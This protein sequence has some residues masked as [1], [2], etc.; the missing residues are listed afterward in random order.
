MSVKC[1]NY[2]KF[3]PLLIKLRQSLDDAA[4]LQYIQEHFENA[5]Q[6]YGVF[7]SRNPKPPTGNSSSKDNGTAADLGHGRGIE[8]SSQDSVQNLFIGNASAYTNLKR[9]FSR[10]IVS[11][12]I[13]DID[14]ESFV[15]ANAVDEETGLTILNLNI[16]KYKYKL[17]NDIRTAIHAPIVNFD[18]NVSDEALTNDINETL[19]LY[20]N[21][22]EDK[23]SIY[24]SYVQ[25]LKFDDLIKDNTPFIIKR[26]I[27]KN[28]A[29]QHK[30]VYQYKG[31]TVKHFYKF[32]D[33]SANAFEQA[34]D[35]ARVLLNTLPELNDSLIPINNTSIG[36]EGF[37]S[38]MSSLKNALMYP[39]PGSI[40]T[41]VSSEVYRGAKANMSEALDTYITWLQSNNQLPANRRTFL[42]TKLRAIKHYIY[43]SNLDENIKNM[44][45]AMFI[46]NVPVN[47]QAYQYDF[48]DHKLKG[49]NLKSGLINVQKGKL[50]DMIKSSIR[51]FK[52][53]QAYFKGILNNY[54][55]TIDD[56][57]RVITFNTGTDNEASITFEYNNGRW[58]FKEHGELDDQIVLNLFKDLTSYLLPEEFINLSHQIFGN[59][60]SLFKQVKDILG[61]VITAGNDTIRY[62]LDKGLFDF[63]S[64]HTLLDPIANVMNVMYGADTRSVIKNLAGNN[65]PTTQLINLAYNA[66][67][68]IHQIKQSA[69]SFNEDKNLIDTRFNIYQNNLIF[70][71]DG[72]IQA[73]LIRSDVLINGVNKSPSQMSVAEVMNLSILEDF[74][75]NINSGTIL[76]QSTTFA[77]KN[78]HFLI[79]FNIS[80]D[81]TLNGETYNLKTLI[82]DCLN[83]GNSSKLQNIF[84]QTRAY[85]MDNV[86]QNVLKDWNKAYNKNFTT[87]EQIDKMIKEQ[88]LTV[89]NIQK[90]F[91]D[92]GLDC[93]ENIHYYKD[94]RTNQIRLN[95]TIKNWY[96]TFGSATKTQERLNRN[97]INFLKNLIENRV[98][99]NKYRSA[100]VNRLASKQNFIKNGWFPNNTGS[101]KL[102]KVYQN[103][104]EINIDESNTYLLTNPGI[105]VELNPLLEAYFM[106]DIL[107]SNEYNSLMMGEVYAH[108]NKNKEGELDTAQYYE[109]SE[110]NRLI[111]QNKRAVIMGATYHPF[112]QELKYG[113]ASTINI[114]VIN[115]MRG[116][117][118]NLTGEEKTDLETMDG[119][120]LSSP[121]QAR[122]E[123]NS[124]LD[125][126]V[127][128]DKKTIMGD[129]DPIYG[130]PTLL[131][132]AVYALTNNR[133]RLSKGSKVS[134]EKIFKKMHSIPIGKYIDVGHA[135]ATFNTEND[136]SKNIYFFDESDQNWYWIS[137]IESEYNEL[138]GDIKVTRTIQKADRYGTVDVNQPT[139]PQSFNYNINTWTIYNLDQ[140]FGGAYTGDIDPNSKKLEFTEYNLDIV[141]KIIGDEDIKDKMISYLVNKTAIKVGA[142]NINPENSWEDDNALTTFKM[143]TEFGGIQMNAEHELDDTEVTEMTQ[144]LSALIENGYSLGTVNQIYSDIG[145]IVEESL[146]EFNQAI[147]NV[148]DK[149]KL[150]R[151]LG[152]ALMDAFLTNDRD[153]IGLA[154]SFI[155]KAN[156][157]L[158]QNNIKYKIPFS[159]PT[160]K[161]AFLATITS[162]INKKGIRRKYAGF[163]GVLTPSFNMIQYYTLD[164]ANLTYD[165]LAK[166]IKL[167]KD[168]LQST[169]EHQNWWNATVEDFINQTNINRDL[170][171]YLVPLDI[172]KNDLDSVDFEDTIV[173]NAGEIDQE[174]IYIDSF[175]KYDDFKSR[176]DLADK[177]IHRWT[178]RPKNL[179]QSNTKFTING[180]T[181]NI[182]D[183]DSV[184]IAHYLSR[185]DLTPEQ[186]LFA[187]QRYGDL[188]NAELKQ[189]A[190]QE[191][192]QILRALEK[193]REFRTS[194]RFGSLT[195][196]VKADSYTVEPA[197]IITGRLNASKF[198][199]DLDE[200]VSDVLI[201]GPSFF[202]KK[203][204]NKYELPNI[205]TELYDFVLYLDDG[206]SLLVKVGKEE[207]LQKQLSK[208]SLSKD[209]TF[210]IVDN[211]VYYNDSEFT[212]INDKQFYSVIDNDKI[213]KNLI[214]FN[215]YDRLTE[216]LN[217]EQVQNYRVNYNNGNFKASAD[218]VYRDKD[219]STLKLQLSSG[220]LIEYQYATPIV[221]AENEEIEF[222]KR[223]EKIAQK[224]YE[225]F[226]KSLNLVGARIPT[227]GMQSFMPMRIVAFTDSE[228]NDI[229]V[230]R[231]QTWLEGSD[232]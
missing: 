202:E 158:Q 76:L 95:E 211:K 116:N 149:D 84:R 118:W 129:V 39:I 222:Q 20:E 67:A 104:K 99:F 60:D 117:V 144:M 128:Y 121:Y 80:Q 101:M 93:F 30:D 19:Q 229:Y 169:G 37:T 130:K 186:L 112:L 160:I 7:T 115:D 4:F 78:T 134:G 44:F 187:T 193:G 43:D 231:V 133:R 126:R 12:S 137:N 35:L 180:R 34:S 86:Y 72:F 171:P 210:K 53:D 48:T 207:D 147:T 150:Y 52:Q 57:G 135:F 47:Y 152:Q 9:D 113:T 1:K 114:A 166:R 17:I 140:I 225:A 164:G 81:I 6:V 102:A 220:R 71:N 148:E 143:S 77:D 14:S 162:L 36:L 22:N 196:M 15:D 65:V 232:Y 209:S 85:K 97:K 41:K 176:Q 21:Y 215:D 98:S 13:F 190:D 145:R 165:N 174:T 151:L 221:L 138:T 119:A 94:A 226:E 159:A 105:K 216:L 31:P 103:G 8:A 228:I 73:P 218:Y 227:Q 16:L 106:T 217:S 18:P 191:T 139:I 197:E 49:D 131:K 182:Y 91:N 189:A 142:G 107:L 204:A 127:G 170:N 2:L 132:W 124:A 168:L 219:L 163:A 208:F 29:Y 100:T 62:P 92:V 59:Q 96:E 146:K 11:M 68:L 203:L 161:N 55:I 122:F 123:N 5:D 110:A 198:G 70:E 172:T 54:G 23:Q 136:Y 188:S 156:D 178:S 90:A 185:K 108:P 88:Q 111:A 38:A 10:K 154:Q 28:S 214:V 155:T 224:Q 175:T 223:N 46:K 167:K 89:N 125:A 27:Y 40:M 50:Q 63:K 51:I 157:S 26:N 64:Y 74:Y 56:K 153:T 213:R 109:F 173:L 177:T 200:N 79:P 58:T 183:L 195:P 24:N 61:I 32:G 181:F 83:T 199:L 69:K 75:D 205:N 33:E 194:T 66:P 25:L 120:G 45:T 192:K 201:E 42:I 141:E 179:K 82:E 87:F 206:N 3:K 230:P 184:R 212:S